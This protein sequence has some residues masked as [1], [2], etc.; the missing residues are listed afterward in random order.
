M[1]KKL[2]GISETVLKKIIMTYHKDIKLIQASERRLHGIPETEDETDSGEGPFS[3]RQRLQVLVHLRTLCWRHLCSQAEGKR[4]QRSRQRSKSQ[5]SLVHRWGERGKG[6]GRGHIKT[7][8]FIS[9]RGQRSR[10]F[11]KNFFF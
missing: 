10:Q 6:Q 4:G 11:K 9:R 8:L 2:H 5:S 1:E 7:P 3:P